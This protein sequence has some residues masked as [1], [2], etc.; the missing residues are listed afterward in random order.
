MTPVS[1]PKVDKKY[2]PELSAS[3]VARARE[4]VATPDE[5]FSAPNMRAVDLAIRLVARGPKACAVSASECHEITEAVIAAYDRGAFPVLAQAAL[6]ALADQL[7]AAAGEV[8]ELS[9]WAPLYRELLSRLER[10]DKALAAAG[11]PMDEMLTD[12]GAEWVRQEL[13][14]RAQQRDENALIAVAAQAELLGMTSLY[15]K[16]QRDRD[17]FRWHAEERGKELREALAKTEEI[18]AR[19]EHAV[20]CTKQHTEQRNSA[21]EGSVLRGVTKL[22]MKVK[23][24]ETVRGHS[25]KSAKAKIRVKKKS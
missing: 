5:V 6:S 7:E 19:Y 12:Q 20:A 1:P 22:T 15:D 18:S 11:A 16:A 4:L 21:L 24:L 10:S 3:L 23:R 25:K 9:K 13:A 8:K 17:F 14:V 2:D